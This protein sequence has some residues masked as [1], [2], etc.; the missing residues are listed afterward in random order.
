M[1]QLVQITAAQTFADIA[2]NE[3]WFTNANFVCLGLLIYLSLLCCVVCCT[4]RNA[5]HAAK[6][7][8]KDA[9]ELETLKAVDDQAQRAT[10][11]QPYQN[12]L[13]LGA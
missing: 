5:K 4:Y 2:S 11:Q 7:R 3:D 12:I 1:Q 8:K 6:Q 13:S 9:F 10:Q